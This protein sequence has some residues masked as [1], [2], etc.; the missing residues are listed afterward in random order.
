[1]SKG[2]PLFIPLGSGIM[3]DL[4]DRL[5]PVGH[6]LD[7]TNQYVKANGNLAKRFGM[8]AQSSTIQPSGL[9]LPTAWQ[10][11]KYKGARVSIGAA[12]GN[13]LALYS[14]TQLAWDA[15]S[16]DRR[17]PLFTGMTKLANTSISQ[18]PKTAIGGGY[19]FLLYPDA[20]GLN[21]RFDVVDGT[22]R[23]IVRSLSFSLGGGGFNGYDVAF[24]NGSAVA[25]VGLS[26]V[27]VMFQRITLST[28]SLTA[29]TFA[30]ATLSLGVFD[31]VVKTSTTLSVV[32]ASGAGNAAAV[33]YV[34]SSTATTG[35][36]PRDSGGAAIPTNAGASWL[37]DL[38]GSGKQALLTISPIAGAQVQWDIPTAGAT[39]QAVTTYNVDASVTTG[40]TQLAAHTITSSAAG[41]FQV[42]LSITASPSTNGF[43]KMAQR[44]SGVLTTGFVLYRSIT[45]LSKAF[46][47]QGDLFACFSYPSDTDG[48]S[49][50]MRLPITTTQP[51]L[52]APQAIFGVGSTGNT[53]SGGSFGI[54][55][56]Q[57]VSTGNQG[58][59]VSAVLLLNR[60]GKQ[61]DTTYGTNSMGAAIVDFAFSLTSDPTS[62]GPP[63][64]GLEALIVPGSPIA[65]FDGVTFAEI[66]A[67]YG[68]PQGTV[69]A[70]A[71][72]AMANATFWYCFVF[73]WMDAQGRL[74]R[75]APSVPQ[76]VVLGGG[77]NQVTGAAP[78]LRLT[79][80]ANVY[81][82]V[83]RGPAND[84]NLFQKVTQVAN[85]LT[86][87]TVAFADNFTDLQLA[88]GEDLYTNGD[89]GALPNTTIPGARFV[90]MFQ[91]RLC[92]I[93]ADDPS[94][95]WF[96]NKTTPTNGV[97]FNTQNVVRIADE[98][99]GLTCA[100]T[101]DDKVVAFKAS[102]SY[103]FSGDGPDDTGAGSFSIPQIVALGLGCTQ[104]RSVVSQKDGVMFDSQ[105]VRSGIEMING[106]LS[107]AQDAN[108][109]P[110]GAAVQRYQNETFV[111]AIL[112]PEQSQVR[113]Y[114]QSGRVLVH[115]LLSHVWTTFLLATGGPTV[116]C[117]LA[118]DGG[119]LVGL[120]NGA[121]WFEDT[122][123]ATYTDAGN[124]MTVTSAIPWI[125]NGGPNGFERVSDFIGMGKTIG[126]HTLTV[127]M[128]TNLDESTVVT[129]KTFA[130]TVA[131]TPKWNWEWIPRFQRMGSF[132][133]VLTET[134][135]GAGWESEG[136]T[137]LLHSR[138]GL[139]RQPTN[140]RGP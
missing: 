71:G 139:N 66:S 112:I 86:A 24:C 85:V 116:T 12:P 103:A 93:S 100:G 40:V 114:C 67:A 117:A 37:V 82:E 48:N 129:S 77:N 30:D 1:M 10:F 74:W 3:T 5:L 107:L 111:S 80:R 34:V 120:S 42:L 65:H 73:A 94:E 62:A 39:R 14:P 60:I 122:T 31:L 97:R 9:P 133:L 50:V 16:T 99:G 26:G 118:V 56:T 90:F 83:Y 19:L 106:G 113:W 72:G 84:Q 68:P 124:L 44:F 6:A 38:G 127:Q 140:T 126:D 137:A 32:Y 63:A 109:M 55:I 132:K 51:T 27:G 20:T 134:S 7:V 102:A 57:V 59:F 95:L 54:G 110:F 46:T 70:A 75:S 25:V 28:M 105:G 22:T 53:T 121:V 130:E 88:N 61:A 79:G 76:S 45:L 87:D 119:A 41:E 23:Q 8:V 47:Y 104:P 89:P 33:D 91:N 123:G 136:V 58:Q 92:F 125:Q 43:T 98:R 4:D 81:V 35:W 18:S 131:S 115:D 17:A 36:S 29:T 13:P 96:S 135:S 2:T 78:T 49:Y 52:S 128:Y 64:E 15:P 108:G 69:T 21:M 11:S 101:M 138:S